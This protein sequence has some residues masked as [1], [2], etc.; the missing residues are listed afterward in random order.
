MTTKRGL[1][2]AISD[3]QTISEG[4]FKDS[5]PDMKVKLCS[6]AGLTKMALEALVSAR[7]EIND[8]KK[9][10]SELKTLKP[11]V[12]GMG[13]KVSDLGEKV[14]GMGKQVTGLGEQMSGLGTEIQKLQKNTDA[15]LDKHDE[16]MA[17]AMD[18]LK[19]I[20]AKMQEEKETR[21]K[22]MEEE[23]EMRKKERQLREES[24]LA[25]ERSCVAPCL[26]LYGL[27]MEAEENNIDLLK[28]IE[29]LFKVIGVKPE[30]VRIDKVMRFGGGKAQAGPDGASATA[31]PARPPP[32]RVVLVDP[33]MKGPLFKGLSNLRGKEEY[34][35]VSIQNEIPRSM[36]PEHKEMSERARSIRTDTGCKTRITFGKGPLILKVF[37]E[38]KLRTEEEFSKMWK[39]GKGTNSSDW[40][41]E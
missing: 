19:G 31:G 12:E 24:Q 28:N 3:C 33:S 16:S 13:E 29:G 11:L 30:D 23:R 35:K 26:I 40:T 14:E 9:D 15:K 8:L 2:K 36:M 25:Y 41:K 10:V 37:Y 17:L 39:D 32:V 1:D 27:K 34:R 38:G 22:Y 7:E 18:A 20:D 21:E 6:V 5:L 4:K